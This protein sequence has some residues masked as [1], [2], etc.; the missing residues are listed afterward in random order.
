MKE[1]VE[2]LWNA[3]AAISSVADILESQLPKEDLPTLEDVRKVLAELS[4]DGHTEEVRALL[5]RYG[6]DKLSLVNPEQYR[7]LLA[8]AAEFSE[9]L[10]HG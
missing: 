9:V 4:R 3:V 1:L 10:N 6:A 5:K 2:K 8:D 7:N